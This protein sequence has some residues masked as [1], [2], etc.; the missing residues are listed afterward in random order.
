MPD[1]SC[2]NCS[3]TPTRRVFSIRSG[4]HVVRC[5]GCDLQFASGYP[6]IDTADRVIYSYK[7]FKP[8]I[9]NQ[10]SRERIFTELLREVESVIGRKGRLLDVGAGEGTLLVAAVKR[11]WHAEGTDIASDMVQHIRERLQLTAHRGVLEE[12]E[13]PQGSFD[14]VVMNHVLEHVQ[15]PR[16]TL[17]AVA[18]LLCDGGAVRVEVPNLASLSSRGK[19]L[20]S[21][22]KLKRNPWRHYDTGHHFWYFTPV[23]LRNTLKA[24][25]LDVM[26][27][28]APSKQW[29]E[30][31]F[32]DR[33]TNRI[34]ARPLLGGHLVAYARRR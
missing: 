27:M 3:D 12:V 8:A 9:D 10:K 19:T 4:G 14:A 29:G 11:G 17:E 32:F 15:N 1:Q 21:R 18:R 34:Y 28:F 31:H 30:K 22:L 24:A 20:Q 26:R 7:Y 25:G 16:T 5:T 23:T 13:L 2:P 33:I 6:E